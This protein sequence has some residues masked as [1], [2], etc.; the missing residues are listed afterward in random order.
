MAPSCRLPRWN[1]ALA[2]Q[3]KTGPQAKLAPDY[4]FDRR[5]ARYAHLTNT[6]N[7][8]RLAH[9]CVQKPGMPKSIY[10]LQRICAAQFRPFFGN[11]LHKI[12]C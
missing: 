8:H 2:C 1:S 3:G 10:S 9:A 12:L 6:G 5:I 4:E 7:R 11:S